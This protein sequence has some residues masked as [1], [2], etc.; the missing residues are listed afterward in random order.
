MTARARFA[1]PAHEVM[2]GKLVAPFAD[3]DGRWL[4]LF[5]PK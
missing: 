3:P 1:T 4:T 2:P 5:G